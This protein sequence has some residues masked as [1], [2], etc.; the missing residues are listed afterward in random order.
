MN[1]FPSWEWIVQFSTVFHPQTNG[2]P[3]VTIRVLENFLRPCVEHRPSTWVD[4]LPLAEF[5]AN[6]AVN[7]SM[8]YSPFYLNS[9][10]S[11]P[12]AKYI[13]GSKGEPKVSNEAVKAALE[14]MKTALVDAESNLTTTQ[15]R[16][17]RAVDKKSRTKEYKIGEE[18]V[19]STANLRTYCPNWPPKIKARWVGPF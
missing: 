13:I 9:G 6:N 19:L 11:P 3:E 10:Q 7:V 4:Q 1:S 2:Q 17:K 18:V 5:V 16:M 14:R 15:Q 8:G 12:C